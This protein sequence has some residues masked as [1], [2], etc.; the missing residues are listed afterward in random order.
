MRITAEFKDLDEF[1]AFVKNKGVDVVE[2]HDEDGPF[3]ELP[4]TVNASM[5]PILEQVV[6]D[7]GY[8]G[9]PTQGSATT[10]SAPTETP[11]QPAPEEEK[12]YSLAALQKAAADL[13]TKDKNLR[14]LMKEKLKEYKVSA[15]RELPVTSYGEFAGFLQELGAT[16]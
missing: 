6:T 15:M 4:T 10:S 1:L 14:P 13:L 12:T 9:G 2:I 3:V 11:P 16:V 7:P 5:V 8:T